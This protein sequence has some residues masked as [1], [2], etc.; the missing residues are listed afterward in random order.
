MSLIEF[1]GNGCLFV[2]LDAPGG[3]ARLRRNE[4]EEE[5]EEKKRWASGEG[6]HFAVSFSNGRLPLRSEAETGGNY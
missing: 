5:E 4:R 3:V 2:H 1:L 6:K